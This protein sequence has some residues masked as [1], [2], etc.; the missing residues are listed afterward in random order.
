MGKLKAGAV[1]REITPPPG[2][3]LY[4]Y[5]LRFGSMRGVHD[6]LWAHFLAVDDGQEQII[7][8]SLDVLHMS[9]DYAERVRAEI[10][11]ELGLKKN[12]IILAC[13][14]THSAPGMHIF[15][16]GGERNI[17]WEENVFEV[18][19]QGAVEAARS[20]EEVSWAGGVG[21]SYIGKNRRKTLGPADPYFPLICFRDRKNKMNAVVASYGCHPVVLDETNLLSSADYVGFFRAHLAEMLGGEAVA[22]FFTGACGDVDP[23]ER[24]KFSIADGF[25][26]ELANEAARIIENMD[27][28]EEAVIEAREEPL[29]IPFGW[30][31]SLEEAEEV[32][33]R[34]QFEH[35]KAEESG[36]KDEIKVKKA[37]L[38]WAEELRQKAEK[39]ELPS[40]LECSLQCLKLG[41]A[42]ILAFPFELFSSI[43]LSIREK[44][45]KG[46]LLMAGY[47]NGYCGYLADKA[48]F[49]EK[50]YEVEDAHK[51]CGLLPLSS[52]A[53][54]IFKQRA[55]SILNLL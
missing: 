49:A 26:R 28:K 30:I 9:C 16:N 40:S 14:H 27:F 38:L 43:S 32:Y 17:E 8:I 15:R 34:C 1:R 6:P 24:G 11:R 48:S 25:G 10:S 12:N 36:K 39:G 52:Q 3:N 37:F 19:L 18:L 45:G 29:V 54:E 50:G 21:F 4:G 2:T 47:A 5:I 42:Y 13:T 55:V 46:I 53:E 20:R 44:S 22:L 41:E 23:I 33:K 7:L 35:K 31:P 51:Y